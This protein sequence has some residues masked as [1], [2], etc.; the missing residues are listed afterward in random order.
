MQSAC[1]VKDRGVKIAYGEI[2][3]KGDV[4]GLTKQVRE[5][6]LYPESNEKPSHF[7]SCFSFTYY[8]FAV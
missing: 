4:H 2:G 8:C 5:V 3:K 6:C 7:E 1:N